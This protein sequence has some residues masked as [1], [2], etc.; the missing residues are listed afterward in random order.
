MI[1]GTIIEGDEID[2]VSTKGGEQFI[3]DLEA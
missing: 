3:R 1:S 2:Y